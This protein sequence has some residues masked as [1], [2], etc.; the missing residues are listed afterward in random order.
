ME[1]SPRVWGAAER[2]VTYFDNGSGCHWDSSGESLARQ[3]R[4]TA[5]LSPLAPKQGGVLQ[6]ERR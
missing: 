1:I 4:L 6:R 3:G 5:R 2:A